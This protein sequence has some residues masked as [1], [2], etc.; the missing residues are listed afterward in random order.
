[1][2]LI[3]EM[4]QCRLCLG[5]EKELISVT[6]NNDL[7][8]RIKNCVTIEISKTDT[9]PTTVCSECLRK[10][11]DW[12]DFRQMCINSNKQLK[13]EFEE[14]HSSGDKN[15]GLDVKEDTWGFSDYEDSDSEIFIKE[16][17][18]EKYRNLQK[19]EIES[20]IYKC[21]VCNKEFDVILEYLEHQDE[22]AG[23]LVFNCDRCNEVFSSRPE[24]VAHERQHKNPCPKC[25]KPILRSSMKIHLIQHTDRFVCSQCSHRF[26]SG[27]TLKQHIITVHTNIK[28]HVC[29]QC[30]KSFSS[31]TAMNV[32]LKTHR[33]E[34]PYA[35]KLCSFTGRTSSS[36][37]IHMATHAREIHGCEICPK[38]FKSWR[39][40][41]DHQRR[42]HSKLKKHECSYCDKKF[43][44]NYMLQVHIRTHTGLRPYLCTLCGKSFIRSD[45]LKEHMATHGT[46][47]LYDCNQCLKKF[48]SK[49]GFAR[50]SCSVV[51]V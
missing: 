27:A 11:D 12:Y 26:N 20:V 31:K 32:H 30:G 2:I 40:L 34:R 13:V 41:A 14:K 24:L 33:D 5:E 7:L 9:L 51:A 39:N 4:A 48:A 37:Y 45:S 19:R 25:G 15:D 43:V 42:V 38:T 47:K 50:H 8:L 36:I 1:E 10:V 23:Q 17:L 21:S 44:D 3:W 28:D 49:R 16:E 6:E 18:E 35:C 46:R 29:E 22:H